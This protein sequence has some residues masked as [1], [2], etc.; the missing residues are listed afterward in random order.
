M[1][2]LRASRG[3]GFGVMAA[4]SL[5]D[6]R[7][8]L[9]LSRAAPGWP[10]HGA[11]NEQESLMASHAKKRS[12]KRREDAGKTEKRPSAAFPAFPS[13]MELRW[14]TPVHAD[15]MAAAKFLWAA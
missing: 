9:A 6:T 13:H 11:N 5:A 3:A 14:R 1:Y 2:P 15:Y 8:R 12:S 4:S 7:T 10:K